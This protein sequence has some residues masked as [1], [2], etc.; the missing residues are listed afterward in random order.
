MAIPFGKECAIC[1]YYRTKIVA[2]IPCG[3]TDICVQCAQKCK[4]CPICRKPI[5]GVQPLIIDDEW[6]EWA[7]KYHRV[8]L[9]GPKTRDEIGLAVPAL[10]D[11]RRK[12][13][14]IIGY[15]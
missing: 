8:P 2:L 6:R 10:A 13:C 11:W 15:S 7:I 5:K 4:M 12:N 1:C 9:F 3:H 14:W